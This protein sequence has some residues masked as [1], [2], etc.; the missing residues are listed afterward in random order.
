MVA[1]R[2]DSMQGEVE[3]ALRRLIGDKP[4]AARRAFTR[5]FLRYLAQEVRARRVLVEH[6]G[7]LENSAL[8]EIARSFG[9]ESAGRRLEHLSNPAL[10]GGV[11]VTQGDNVYDASI[12]G[13]LGRLSVSTR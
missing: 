8:E 10:I 9:V 7:P 12:A 4:L 13:R 11:R 5:S 3:P 1:E 2:G 6:A